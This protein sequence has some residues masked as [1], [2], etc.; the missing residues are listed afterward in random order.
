MSSC[1]QGPLLALP[2]D[3]EVHS[4]SSA[5]T[6]TLGEKKKYFQSIDGLCNGFLGIS[7]TRMLSISPLI[8]VGMV[9]VSYLLV[10]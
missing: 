9:F 1:K 6:D 8:F 4:V 7:V 2:P 10:F 5:V 3:G